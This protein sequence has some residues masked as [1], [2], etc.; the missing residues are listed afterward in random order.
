MNTLELAESMSG[1]TVNW[2]K[3]TAK[4][5]DKVI[6]GSIIIKEENKYR[7]RLFYLIKPLSFWYPAKS[8]KVTRGLAK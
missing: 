8:A 2:V 6:A 4:R 5:I 1:D 3:D 7:N